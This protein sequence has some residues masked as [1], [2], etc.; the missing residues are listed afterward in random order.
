MVQAITDKDFSQETDKGVVL[1][2]FWA[3]WCGP[4][5]MQS[6][7]VE[8]LAEDYDGEVKFTKMDVD[9]NPATAQSFGIMSI[10]T[11]LVKKDGEVVETLVGYHTK[12]QLDQ[13]LKQYTA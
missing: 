7:V 11:L 4:C 2:D 8:Q 1:T 12:D 13:V 9:A 5:R 10:P 3:T 6:P